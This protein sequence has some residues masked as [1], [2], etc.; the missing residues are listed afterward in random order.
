MYPCRVIMAATENH[1]M[2]T[3]TI[4][5][6]HISLLA[7]SSLYY[8]LGMGKTHPTTANKSHPI[9]LLSFTTDNYISGFM[10]LIHFSAMGIIIDCSSARNTLF[11]EL[12]SNCFGALRVCENYI[13]LNSNFCSCILLIFRRNPP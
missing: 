13:H 11:M 5:E 12:P 2:P 9:T 3:Q 4:I 8:W 6:P 10:T 7:K 1:D